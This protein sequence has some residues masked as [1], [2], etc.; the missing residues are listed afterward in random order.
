MA[1]NSAPVLDRALTFS[2]DQSTAGEYAYLPD[3]VRG[4]YVEIIIYIYFSTGS[5]AGKVQVQ[6]APTIEY[7]GTWANVG[8]TIDWAAQTSVKYAAISGV[9]G[10][11][12]LKIDTTVTTG[13]VSAYVIAS[14]N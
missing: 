13:T 12:R 8:S 14:S 10:A 9:F 5:A 4:H 2:G 11:V 3:V 1:G 7:S 6:T